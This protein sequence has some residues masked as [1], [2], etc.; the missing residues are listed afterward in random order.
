MLN[1]SFLK[2]FKLALDGVFLK[3]FYSIDFIYLFNNIVP[4]FAVLLFALLLDFYIR[5]RL[6]KGFVL[7]STDLARDFQFFALNFLLKVLIIVL[8]SAAFSVFR[9]PK[10]IIQIAASILIFGFFKFLSLAAENVNIERFGI[11]LTLVNF[12]DFFDNKNASDKILSG[13]NFNLIFF[14]INLLI[15]IKILVKCAI[16]YCIVIVNQKILDF[17]LPKIA[18][19]TH[20][21]KLAK[22]LV[23]YF[24]YTFFILNVFTGIGLKGSHLAMIG[25][26]V[27]IGI[28]FGLQ[29]FAANFMSGMLLMSE[30][31]FKIG[32]VIALENDIWGQIIEINTRTTIIETFN[33]EKILI[34]NEQMLNSALKHLTLDGKKYSMKLELKIGN[35]SNLTLALGI[36]RT[37]ISELAERGFIFDK[38]YVKVDEIAESG[39]KL[40]VRLYFADI[41]ASGDFDPWTV[42]SNFLIKIHNDFIANG[43]KFAAH[44]I[45][46][47]HSDVQ[48]EVL[49]SR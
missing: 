10:L 8:L 11:F 12:I 23:T 37:A 9:E 24:L 7:S 21:V 44:N 20:S 4:E 34:P 13:V 41:T 14:Q 33:Q 30:N 42:K 26:A 16:F 31:K 36:T 1:V 6:S 27:G 32:D 49:L 43:I 15:L 19:T 39:I 38:S 22:T 45:T 47:N 17:V 5:R 3:H 29:K 48:A 46:L 40:F 28:G 18:K 35:A 25:S 2:D